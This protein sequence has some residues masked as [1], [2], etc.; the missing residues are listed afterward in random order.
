[1][2]TEGIRPA[3]FRKG[4]AAVHPS[5]LQ[6]H[7]DIRTPVV[8]TLSRFMRKHICRLSLVNPRLPSSK[9]AFTVL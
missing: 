1:M 7:E 3:R 8:Y 5:R 2:P 9:G 6:C 4:E